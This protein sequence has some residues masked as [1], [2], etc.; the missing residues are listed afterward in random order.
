MELFVI[1]VQKSNL[2]KKKEEA[3]LVGGHEAL[4]RGVKCQLII[5]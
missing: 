4:I 5:K 3:G 2:I 1:F